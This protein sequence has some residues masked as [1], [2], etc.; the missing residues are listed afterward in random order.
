MRIALVSAE[1]WPLSKTGGLADYVFSLSNALASLGHSVDVITPDYSSKESSPAVAQLNGTEG[2]TFSRQRM[3]GWT[4]VKAV[5]PALFAREK[6]YGYED[7]YRRFAL[8][9]KAAASYIVSEGYDVVHCNDWPTGYIPLLL[10]Q[11]KSSIPSLFT[12]HNMEFQ[13]I[14]PPELLDEIGI[15]RS[16]FHMGGVEYY[17]NVSSMKAGIVYSDALVTVSP[18]YSREI[19]TPEFGFGMDGIIRKH[20]SKLSGILN[21]I[22]YKMW[23]PSGDAEI[24]ATFSSS[25]M[26]GKDMCKSFL[27]RE[28][29][30]PQVRRPLLAFIGRLWKQK[31]MDLLLDALP[32]VRGSYQLIVLGTGDTELMR[33]I[34]NVSS[35]NP[36]VRAIMRYDEKLAHR[37]YS[38]ADI[39][40]MPSR[41]EPCGL[42]QMI[43]M[44]YGTVPVVRK[45]GGLA[46]TVHNFDR[47]TGEGEGFVFID[48]SPQELADAISAAIRTYSD[49]DRWKNLVGN[50]MNHDFSWETSAGRYLSLYSSLASVASKLSE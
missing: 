41:F 18:T 29:S 14:S 38:A 35:A 22:D 12:I 48:S 15:S 39:F 45:T 21:G 20:S 43:S 47:R 50:C 37:I 17:G 19:Q 5:S 24:R 49:R 6:L 33:R 28:F 11:A 25:S 7:D 36:A 23:D 32:S 16:H 46:D 4:A 26:G 34:E 3:N 42:G 2:V 8:F 1:V 44:R 13:G 40:I 27:Q 10:K 31:G 30:L 9:S